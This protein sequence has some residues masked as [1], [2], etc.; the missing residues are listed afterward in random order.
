MD[1]EGIVYGNE[2]MNKI[3]K[4]QSAVASEIFTSSLCAGAKCNYCLGKGTLILTENLL[5][6]PIENIK[7]NDYVIG[8]KKKEKSK[9]WWYTKSKVIAT[10]KR[11]A[12]TYKIITDKGEVICTGEHKWL[13]KSHSC[14]V[15]TIY[16]KPTKKLKFN[17][18][19]IKWVSSYTIFEENE[20]YKKGWL[21]GVAFGDGC[22]STFINQSSNTQEKF[23]LRVID[24]KIIDRFG[25]YLLDLGIT[26]HFTPW[27]YN[28][29]KYNSLIL[30]GK[31]NNDWLKNLRLK[32][33]SFY[34]G[35]LGGAF[36]A[37][38]SYND[39]LRFSQR[40]GKYFNLIKESLRGLNISYII[41]DKFPGGGRGN[42][43]NVFS[44]RIRK[45]EN[46]F[47]FFSLCNPILQRKKDE[48]FKH[49]IRGGTKILD[50]IPNGVQEVYDIQTET[51][52]FIANGM[53]SHNCYI[54]K[55]EYLH[56]LQKKL[57]E[58]LQSGE[59]IKEL[60]S[61]YGDQL[62]ALSFWG[63]EPTTLIPV[64]TE[65]IP[66]IVNAF[67][68][69]KEFSFSTNMLLDPK[70]LKDFILKVVEQGRDI[71]IKIQISIDG[72]QE[73]TDRNRASGATYKIKN[74]LLNLLRLLQ[75]YD[76]GK[77]KVEFTFKPTFDINNLIWFDQEE[78]RF[79]YYLFFFDEWI[80]LAKGINRNKNIC[81]NLSGVPTMAVPGTYS[82]ADGRLF[83]KTCW[84]LGRLAEENRTR[85]FLK[86]QR[87]SFNTYS[88]RL[89]RLIDYSR[90][91]FSKPDMF[92]CSGGRSQSQL[93]EQQDLH[94][95]HRTLFMNHDEYVKDLKNEGNW[96]FL[97]NQNNRIK[98]IKNKHI[99]NIE[100]Q[101]EIDRV[102]YMWST[103]HH[104]TKQKLASG[105]AL[106]KELVYSK[107]INEIYE[108][109]HMA[110]LFS[111][112]INFALSCP[113][114]SVLQCGSLFISP[115]SLFRLFGASNENCFSA[116]EIILQECREELCRRKN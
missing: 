14:F 54:E 26:P 108:D 82:S 86:H 101:L 79:R 65:K 105:L 62:Q 55:T 34:R 28:G 98:L 25:K 92:S 35:F 97:L 46:I 74:N 52:N 38:G 77:T 63:A 104:F 2:K 66:E 80:D 24:D 111:I 58:K 49:S 33:E 64:I 39:N 106:I 81:L 4:S 59:Y 45:L 20:D 72:P 13:R 41:E 88:H 115:I 83:A 57:I 107:Q 116:F 48:I 61:L 3:L 73:I 23:H 21:Y 31:N 60:Q 71:K 95:C 110:M 96:D 1:K 56:E 18:E 47:K 40:K 51:E 91:F 7:E 69:L 27:K 99:V 113:A 32:T 89:M 6:V 103:Y 9:H 50:I 43:K 19:D 87:G 100:N 90:E 44:I 94:L 75:E 16:N 5:W 11:T 93:G 53:I 37:E 12:Q 15:P 85:A 67:P 8:F 84:Q 29:K 102:F 112:F 70:I 114:E 36:D 78:S 109:E 17:K 22:F 10:T 76:L 42:H 68:N 30:Y